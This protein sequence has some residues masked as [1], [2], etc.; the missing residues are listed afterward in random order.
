M[1]DQ[2]E[3][4]YKITL[5]QENFE[6][7]NKWAKDIQESVK[8][9][10]HFR[11]AINE[12]RTSLG[13]V[14]R[15]VEELEEATDG[16]SMDIDI[17]PAKRAA[18]E[19]RL[20]VLRLKRQIMETAEIDIHWDVSKA[21]TEI[22][23]L[24]KVIKVLDPIDKKKSGK[25]GEDA[26]TTF[27]SKFGAVM[28][29]GMAR[30]GIQG[31]SALGR[32][33]VGV[34]PEVAAVVGPI[35]A[36]IVGA[37]LAEMAAAMQAVGAMG[38]L[39][40]GILAAFQDPAL[41]A[42]AGA[43]VEE[44]RLAFASMGT[45]LRGPT[46]AALED[47]TAAVRTFSG[48]VGPAFTRLAPDIAFLGDMI[49]D[50]VAAVSGPLADT[51]DQIRP[52]IRE[53]ALNVRL[54]GQVVVEAFKVLASQSAGAALALRFLFAG[55]TVLVV[56]LVALLTTL[57]L[58]FTAVAKAADWLADRL[59]KLAA[60]GVKLQPMVNGLR[61]LANMLRPVP[62]E[63]ADAEE[64]MD[65]L[66][67]AGRKLKEEADAAALATGNLTAEMEKAEAQARQTAEQMKG[68]FSDLINQMLGLDNAFLSVEQG[69]HDVAEAAKE[70]GTSMD[71][72]TEAG[73]RNQRAL[74]S[75]VGA[76]GELRDQ[77]VKQGHTITEANQM[78]SDQIAMLR[79]HAKDVGLDAEAVDA[80]IG[81]Y[82][83]IPEMEMTRLVTMFDESANPEMLYQ[84][85][86]ATFGFPVAQKVVAEADPTSV[87][88]TIQYFGEQ[89][90]DPIAM[91]TM[92]K[93]DPEGWEAL[94]TRIK[95]AT[96]QEVTVNVGASVGESFN[97]VDTQLKAWKNEAI[98][99]TVTPNMNQTAFDKITEQLNAMGT[100][101]YPIIYPTLDPGAKQR[102]ETWYAGLAG[103]SGGTT[104]SAV[105]PGFVNDASF[106]E[107]NAAPTANVTIAFNDERFES[108]LDVGVGA[109]AADTARSLRRR[110]VVSVGG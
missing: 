94:Q 42:A 12:S 64:G 107:T 21:M 15:A 82:D 33:M 44:M 45:G 16:L 109:V 106:S 19:L 13:Q 77:W 80:L 85:M 83:E 55:L 104:Q 95:N 79:Q 81:K 20:E 5:E 58:P 51:M 4:V 73:I 30:A 3:L 62:E 87:T 32:A 63:A 92:M 48:V 46:L 100:S 103:I 69:W 101:R 36:V 9:M 14:T 24:E 59:N 96:G 60:A 29:Q 23:R 27:M 57:L 110:R 47:I 28:I 18:N 38:F 68:V 67:E 84:Q 102:I 76:I 35:A 25:A 50:L 66:T 11:D 22:N 8:E 43:L 91:R 10:N 56:G 37:I 6:A 75:Q 40:V 93:N 7:A 105:P 61:M 53:I 89:F 17:D 99:P 78:Y 52:V 54:F 65:G 1:V 108:L 74:L 90:G 86:V 34:A 41:K 97:K 31:L 26:A 72:A 39:T 88:A 2:E 98:N 70:N 71:S 49:S